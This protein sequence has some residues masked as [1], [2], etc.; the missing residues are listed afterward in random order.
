M[1]VSCC[2]TWLSKSKESKKYSS[3]TYFLK[4]K[5]YY[6]AMLDL[7]MIKFLAYS[8]WVYSWHTDWLKH[9]KVHWW[10]RGFGYV[11]DSCTLISVMFNIYFWE[12]KF[13]T[14]LIKMIKLA[15][16]QGFESISWMTA[17]FS[18]SSVEGTRFVSNKMSLGRHKGMKGSNGFI[19]YSGNK[20]QLPI[21]LANCSIVQ[22][23]L[24]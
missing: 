21:A 6:K 3:R 10:R 1:T 20:V 14:L 18:I 22:A 15:Y 17:E 7:T 9:C 13:L 5:Y 24:L 2:S 4:T 11:I 12:C 16:L 23:D 8:R 19:R